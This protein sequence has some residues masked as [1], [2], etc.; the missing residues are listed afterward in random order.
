MSESSVTLKPSDMA[1]ALEYLIKKHQPAIVTGKP[2]GGKTDLVVQA[3]TACQAKT[4][5]I[6]P[7]LGDPTDGKGLPWFQE[8]KD[9]AVFLPFEEAY[10][11]I[12]AKEELVVFLDDLGQAMPAVQASWM[13]PVL[14]RRIAG[15]PIPSHVTFMA[16]TNLRTHKAAVSGILEPVKGRFTLLHLRSD[17]D[18]FCTNLFARGESEYCLTEE[19]ILAGAS[20]LRTM[21]DLLNAFDPTADMTNSP[22]ERNWVNAFG[23]TY[24]GLRSSIELALISGRVGDGAAATY[25]AYLRTYRNMMSLDAILAD[26]GNAIIPENPSA[27][28]CISVGLANK[29]TVANFDRHKIY[30]ERLVDHSLGEFAALL[31]RDSTR[32]N[33]AVATTKAYIEM[34]TGKVG[35]LINGKVD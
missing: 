21:P 30:A 25:T 28:W 22:T 16:A 19:Q 26:P 5:V 8:K 11:I 12:H 2:G 9:Y 13:M 6:H 27:L 14:N 3:A 1:R 20:F 10:Q 34:A 29:A 15:Q 33:P 18:D 35:N 4:L 17:L 23:H 24:T 31:V 32:R 7:V